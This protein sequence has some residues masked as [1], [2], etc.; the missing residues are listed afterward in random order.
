CGFRA[1]SVQVYGNEDLFFKVKQGMRD[2]LLGNKG[3]YTQYFSGFIDF[4]RVKRKT[5]G[6]EYWFSL[7]A[8][9]QIAAD[10]FFALVATF[11]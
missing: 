8:C 1:I 10:I 7:P 4:D 6:V 9:V 3:D 5:S 2:T 11:T